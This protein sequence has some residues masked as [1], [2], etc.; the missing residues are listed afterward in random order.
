MSVRI[1]DI[2]AWLRDDN[3]SEGMSKEASSNLSGYDHEG[4]LMEKL[5]SQFEDEQFT[6]LA[7]DAWTMGEI[8]GESFLQTLEKRALA[9]VDDR[10]AGDI[11]DSTQGEPPMMA[12]AVEDKKMPQAFPSLVASSIVEKLINKQVGEGA[13]VS[14]EDP[15][16]DAQRQLMPVEDPENVE[17]TGEVQKKVAHFLRRKQRLNEV[18]KTAARR[19]LIDVLKGKV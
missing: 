19:L 5:A 18:D 17:E 13:S 7:N 1:K 10:V 14:G 16:M 9:E 3:Q 15:R 2:E 6:K 4:T 12:Q 8:M 11:S